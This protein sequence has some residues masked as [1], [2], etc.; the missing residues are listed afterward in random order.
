M[1]TSDRNV[2]ES[3][4]VARPKT[5]SRNI[6][7]R[8]RSL[9]T[10]GILALTS[11][12]GP[13]PA[14]ALP[15]H[16]RGIELGTVLMLRE[17]ALS[18]ARVAE[19]ALAGEQPSPEARSLR[20]IQTI[21]IDPGHGGDN[22][23]AIGVAHVH[24]KFMTLELAYEL[25][26]ELRRRH[27]GVRVLLTRYWDRD[28]SLEQRIHM[29]NE[30]GADLFLSL[31]Y[32]AAVHDRAL[33][34]E[35]YFLTTEQAIP[36]AAPRQSE[37]L[38]SA[39]NT[40]AG[41]APEDGDGPAAAPQQ[42]VHN[43]AMVTLQRDLERA[44]Q[45]RDSGLL[46][47]TVQAS[48]VRHTGATDRGVKQA[49]FGVLRGALMPAVVIEAGFVTHPKEGRRVLRERHRDRVIVALLESVETFD[50]ALAARRDGAEAPP[51][52]PGAQEA[53]AQDP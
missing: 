16:V 8:W 24:E 46:A 31:H 41:L 25:R 10:L 2:E 47:E 11:L 23:G 39:S 53:P 3:G 52:A 15:P 42:G 1:P 37:P 38:A 33:G 35:T 18:L 51:Q 7:R 34:V 6:S 17:Q 45:H 36:G 14:E 20:H 43:D 48:M 50:Q 5:T 4:V 9:A 32:N 22:Q 30:V 49:N 26:D 40:V 29:A 13:R 28:M 21:V 12:A 27:P 44:R 19:T